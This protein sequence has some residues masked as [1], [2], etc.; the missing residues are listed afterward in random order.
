VESKIIKSSLSDRLDKVLSKELGVSRNQVEK[1]IKSKMVYVNQNLVTKPSFKLNI[2]DEIS[3]SYIEPSKQSFQEF[4]IEIERLYEDDDVLVLNKPA[5]VVIHPAPSVKEPTLVDWLRAQNIRLSTI[6]GEERNGIVHRLDKDTSGAIIVAKNNFAHEALSKQLQDRSLGRYYLAIINIPLK[7]NLVVDK[8][9]A[10]NPKNRLKMAIVE[11]GRA[12]KSAF[13][14]VA[15]STK[16]CELIAAKLFSGR[17]H[18][19]RVH[20]G[21]L[22]RFILGDKLYAPSSHS[23]KSRMMLHARLLYFLHPRDGRLVEVEAPLFEDMQEYLIKN[24][25]K[26]LVDDKISKNSIKSLFSNI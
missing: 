7:E 17:T 23:F 3:Y 26:D 4:D 15:V 25:D 18:Q 5:G 14:K 19:I 8:P 21:S 20:L 1:L 11:G 6:S 2:D 9:I 24:F 13:S 22:N 12:S 16:K 10:R